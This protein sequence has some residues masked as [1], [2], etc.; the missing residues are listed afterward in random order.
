MKLIK[1]VPTSTYTGDGLNISVRMEIT[2]IFTRKT[3]HFN[4]VGKM[5]HRFV[6]A[7]YNVF[8]TLK[9]T[10]T[11]NLYFTYN[12]SYKIIII[13]NFILDMYQLI[14]ISNSGYGKEWRGTSDREIDRQI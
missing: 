13:K 9:C 6:L 14:V 7:H 4:E 10:F 2:I 8:A 11:T 5:A 1:P 12:S 3:K